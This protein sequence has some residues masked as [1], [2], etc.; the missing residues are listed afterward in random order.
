MKKNAN[1]M[2]LTDPFPRLT[3]PLS[4]VRTAASST[5][6]PVA[7]LVSG[8]IDSSILCVDLLRWHSQVHPIYV[9]FGLRWESV[10]LNCLKEFL[11]AVRSQQ[12]ELAP[13]TVLEEPISQVYGA[14]WSN[15]G[16]PGVPGFETSD[17]AVY[18]PGRNVLLATKAAVWCRVRN[19]NTLAFGTLMENPFPDSS[20][21]FFKAYEAV[22]NHAMQGH[23]NIVRPYE[24]LS[25]IQ[26][27]GRG[28]ELPLHLTFSCL[29]PIE[30]KH[31]GV[32][33]K[34]QERREAFRKSGW[35]DHTEYVENPAATL[36]NESKACIE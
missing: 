32:C 28:T 31:C 3:M 7:V 21:T 16:E 6:G 4:N 23:L 15:I 30:C 27:I 13:L 26:V 20:P 34:C 19:I 8:G 10:E 29:N 1:H 33:N 2:S 25:K 17:E 24:R 35:S 5:R 14:H 12:Y 22:L 36:Q 11:Q 9:K 18:L